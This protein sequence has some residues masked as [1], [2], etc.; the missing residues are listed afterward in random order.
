M[1]VVYRSS[2]CSSRNIESILRSKIDDLH[3]EKRIKNEGRNERRKTQ[4]Y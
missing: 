1:F 2:K 4:K 3:R